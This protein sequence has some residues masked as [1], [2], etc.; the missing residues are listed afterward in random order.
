M[1]I[2]AQLIGT[3][4]GREARKVGAA[5]FLNRLALAQ[6]LM[7]TQVGSESQRAPYRSREISLASPDRSNGGILK[8]PVL[9]QRRSMMSP[10]FLLLSAADDE[11]KSS[12][13]LSKSALH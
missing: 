10:Q 8:T 3:Q 12:K 4:V 2:G 1:T 5:S 9:Q 6:S 11:S 13:W 7:T